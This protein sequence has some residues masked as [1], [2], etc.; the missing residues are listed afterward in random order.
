ME[1]GAFAIEEVRFGP[2]ASAIDFDAIAAVWEQVYETECGARLPPGY[3]DRAAEDQAPLLYLLARHA[4]SGELA[5]VVRLRTEPHY[6]LERMAVLGR[7][8]S[9]GLGAL[10]LLSLE[11]RAQAL[12]GGQLDRLAIPH[13]WL[14]AVPFYLRHGYELAGDEFERAGQPHRP[15]VKRF[16]RPPPRRTFDVLVGSAAEPLYDDAI[17]IRR[18]VF[19]DEQGF[20]IDEE[21]RRTRSA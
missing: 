9:R 5:G 2:D 20:T 3:L 1:P 12:A 19:V 15:L 18:V 10:L 11:Q 8:R 4:S 17:R 6:A 7:F 13:A 21:V 14:P 16:A